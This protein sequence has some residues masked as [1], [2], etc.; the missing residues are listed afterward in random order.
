M[1]KTSKVRERK[2]GKHGAV[3]LA[4]P[5]G[6]I[7]VDPRQRPKSYLDTLIHEALHIAFPELSETRVKKSAKIIRDV[8][9][10]NNYR[11][12]SQ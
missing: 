9:W 12:T 3:G 5:S 11:K 7:E 10:D 6:L 4:H 2:L 1:A 8:L